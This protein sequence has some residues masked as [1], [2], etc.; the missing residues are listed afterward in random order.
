MALVFR[1]LEL[2]S[3]YNVNRPLSTLEY[4]QAGNILYILTFRIPGKEY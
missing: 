2:L 3:E 4:Y 1:L